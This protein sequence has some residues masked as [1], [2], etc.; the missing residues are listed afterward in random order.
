MKASDC[1]PLV[2]VTRGEIIESI[3]YG[4]FCVTDSHGEELACFGNPE[5][6]TFPRSSLKPFQALAFI[7]RGGAEAFNFTQQEIAIMCASHAGTDEHKSVLESMHKKIGIQEEDLACGVHWPGDAETREAMKKAGGEPTPFRHNCSGKHT[8]MLA[9]ARLGDYSKKDYLDPQHPV[10]VSIRETLAEMLEMGPEEMPLGV[11][12]C[13]APVYGVPLQNM[14]KAAALLADPVGLSRTRAQACRVITGAML[15]HPAMI[16]GPGKFDTELMTLAAGRVFSKGGAEGY[17]IIGV[18]PGVMD[19]DSPGLGIAIKI[20]DGDPKGRGRWL[21]GLTI[22]E[23]LGILDK[24]DL[25]RLG[26]YGD[27]AVKNWRGLTVGEIRLAFSLTDIEV[28]EA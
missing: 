10:Q 15:A 7:E 1:V 3:H 21:V 2:E 6:V 24:N 27:R 4:A 26:S 20:S 19:E 8:G 17:Q 13:S 22:L 11:D 12:G 18:M 28:G 25:Q 5:L 14:A 16:A 23:A 9:Y